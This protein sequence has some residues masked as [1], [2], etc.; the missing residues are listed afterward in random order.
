MIDKK[1]SISEQVANLPIEAQL[2]F[3]WSISHADDLGLLPFSKKTLKAMII[4][5]VEM[6]SET[7]E[8]HIEAIVLQ[9]LWGIF[10]CQ[11][12]K[13][14]R[15]KTFLKNQYLK[16]DRQ[17]MTLIK[18]D[19]S[20]KPKESWL[21]LTKLTGLD[22][23]G[24]QMENIVFQSEPETKRN[25]TKR[26]ERNRKEGSMR[27]GGQAPTPHDKTIEFFSMTNGILES[28]IE[29]LAENTGL[30]TET[31]RAELKKFTLYWTERSKSGKKQRWEMEKTFEVDRR[32]SKWLSNCQKWSKEKSKGRGLEV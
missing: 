1:I 27:E 21:K 11:G 4:P 30:S 19:F 18:I 13:Y 25:E 2:I 14:Y 23:P 12:E 28:F 6:D 15:I 32:F 17:P 5:M 31:V 26:I 8:K 20:E 3:T 9:G 29:K 16:R 22:V 7:F 24:F 10:E